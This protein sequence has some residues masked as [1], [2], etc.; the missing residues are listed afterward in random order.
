MFL[1]ESLKTYL[2]SIMINLEN[3]VSLASTWE[4]E[5]SQAKKN[6]TIDGS[7]LLKL[8]S[9][10]VS[11]PLVFKAHIFKKKISFY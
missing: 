2:S 3:R 10:T 4:A 7:S 11:F 6:A 9:A 8:F 1:I 5:V